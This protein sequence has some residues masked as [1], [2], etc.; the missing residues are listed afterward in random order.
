[1]S[2]TS[3]QKQCAADF[4]R[5][6]PIRFLALALFLVLVPALATAAAKDS[7]E[8]AAKTACLAG[9]YAKGVALLAELYVKTNDINYLFNQGRCF[10]QNGKYEEAIVRFREYLRKNKDAGRQADPEAESHIAESQAVIDKQK[11]SAP[12][13]AAAAVPTPA[14]AAPVPAAVVMPAPTPP[15]QPAPP[16][17]APQPLPVPVPPV[18]SIST[19]P[20]G[21]QGQLIEVAGAP[22]SPGAGLRIAGIA[23]AAAGAV[24]LAAGVILNVKANSLS[25]ELENPTSYTRSKE[26][27]RSSYQTL[28]WVSYSAGA[29]CLAGGA[30]LYYLGYRQG[31]ANQ[32]A[33]VPVA[34]T[35]QFGALLTGAF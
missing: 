16:G 29:A 8:R 5:R 28:G 25:S 9:D 27:S 26:S 13:P 21:L 30:V 11:S 17:A 7:K 19:P 35:G 32:L 6:R 12:T 34:G 15:A 3:L 24:G 22:A 20:P 33:L 31:H 14:A 1:M 10:E 2:L 23:V 4:H 18:V